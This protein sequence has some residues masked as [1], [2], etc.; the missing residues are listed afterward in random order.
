MYIPNAFNPSGINKTFRPEGSFIDYK[1]SSMEI[2]D[3]WGGK[4][5]QILDI[6]NG[7]DGKD[8]KGEYC[9]IGVY[10]YEIKITGTNGS[11]QTKSGLVTIIN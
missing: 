3:R 11:I 5:K 6:T 9:V 1:S 10:L 8:S 7:W 2:Y 4:V